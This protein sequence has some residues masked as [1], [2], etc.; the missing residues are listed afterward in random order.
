[1]R[2]PTEQQKLW[3]GATDTFLLAF[4]W[5]AVALAVAGAVLL[6]G[7]ETSEKRLSTAL[8]IPG[9]VTRALEPLL[10]AAVYYAYSSLKMV[11]G[12]FTQLQVSV[13]TRVPVSLALGLRAYPTTSRLPCIWVRLCELIC[14]KDTTSTPAVDLSLSGLVSKT[15]TNLKS[16]LAQTWSQFAFRS[17]MRC[18]WRPG[19]TA[20]CLRSP[21]EG[22]GSPPCAHST[23]CGL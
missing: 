1:M 12:E 14:S 3:T 8:R 4:T 15:Q 13:R 6:D 10:M 2:S 23:P 17:G 19:S 20:R 9:G 16:Q 7:T 5:S 11:T 22:S 18:C 21:Q